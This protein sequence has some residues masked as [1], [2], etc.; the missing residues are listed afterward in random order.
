[1][2]YLKVRGAISATANI[3]KKRQQV[4]TECART[5]SNFKLVIQ[6][7]HNVRNIIPRMPVQPLFQSLLIHIM[8]NEPNRTTQHEQRID[9]TYTDI[10]LRFLSG[11]TSA[12]VEH[13]N[14]G[15]RNHTV[16]IQNQIRLLAGRQLFYFQRV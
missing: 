1:M 13:V 11:K 10:L 6:L 7:W 8:T 5:S 15:T 4:Q 2:K 12:I 3:E 14:E 16:N 9:G